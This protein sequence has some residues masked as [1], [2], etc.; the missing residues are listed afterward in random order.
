MNIELNL[1]EQKNEE[2][3]KE[4]Y[5]DAFKQKLEDALKEDITSLD[6]IEP[7]LSESCV[8]IHSWHNE[9]AHR[10]HHI[11]KISHLS[12]THKHSHFIPALF[13]IF[14]KI[15]NIF[16]LKYLTEN[17]NNPSTMLKHH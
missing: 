1:N 11:I 3:G 5:D 4:W 13:V 14:Y 10:Q 9:S 12:F 2:I 7:K 6:S 8:L 16:L 15:S 17:L